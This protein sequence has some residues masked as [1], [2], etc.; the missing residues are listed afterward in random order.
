MGRAGRVFA[1]AEAVGDDGYV[2]EGAFI[3]M[4]VVNEEPAADAVAIFVDIKMFFHGNASFIW[5][6]LYDVRP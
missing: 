2:V 5:I 3:F 4:A 1:A 6:R